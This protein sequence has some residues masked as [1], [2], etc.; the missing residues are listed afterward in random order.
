MCLDSVE[1]G[2][3]KIEFD[4][5]QVFLGSFDYVVCIFF[6]YEWIKKYVKIVQCCL[7]IENILNYFTKWALITNTN[8]AALC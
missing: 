8:A 5:H 3:I 1:D 7:K 6:K 4:L 2:H